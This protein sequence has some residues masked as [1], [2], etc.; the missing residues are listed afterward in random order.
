MKEK[1]GKWIEKACKWIKENPIKFGSIL[2]VII[3]V[4]IIY[5]IYRFSFDKPGELGDFFGGIVGTIF[6]FV[7]VVILAKTLEQQQELTKEE[8]KLQSRQ[9]FDVLFNELLTLYKEQFDKL[10]NK[11]YFF[12][13]QKKKMQVDFK[14]KMDGELKEL[15]KGV[16]T[17]N[18]EI[19]RRLYDKYKSKNE[20]YDEFKQGEKCKKVVYSYLFKNKKYSSRFNRINLEISS[21]LYTE[22]YVEHREKIALYFR[23][24]YRILDLIDTSPLLEDAENDKKSYAKILRGQLTENELFFIRYNAMSIYGRNFVEYI[25]KYRI[26]KHLPVLE[27]LEFQMFNN[28]DKKNSD[29][30]DVEKNSEFVNEIFYLVCEEIKKEKKGYRKGVRILDIESFKYKL[31]I[32]GEEET[33]KEITIRYAINSN[34][35][36][37]GVH[38]DYFTAL[39]DIRKD[40]IVFNLI[41]YY[42]MYEM[43]FWSNFN[44]YNEGAKIRVRQ[45]RCNNTEYIISTIKSDKPIQIGSD[46]KKK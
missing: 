17:E 13:D 27:L 9:R 20:S 10:S 12:E 19:I 5:I 33:N 45:F 31:I 7:S 22:F 43:F 42:F 3:I 36:T 35:G 6:T 39:E 4:V 41:L 34:V 40:K 15:E 37:K 30:N 25:N 38:Y 2:S 46:Y 44:K 11:G 24:L 21:K 32:E 26:L 29:S 28:V 1:D 16:I 23:T 8:F 14:K 18:S